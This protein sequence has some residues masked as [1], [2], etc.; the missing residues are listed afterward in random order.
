MTTTIETLRKWQARMGH[1]Y[2]SAAHALGVSRTTYANWLAG[3]Y[4]IDRRTVLACMALEAGFV[5][6][7]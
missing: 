2:D 4:P 3:T 5:V 1:T 7:D 6:G